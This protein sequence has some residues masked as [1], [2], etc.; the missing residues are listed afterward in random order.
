M[1]QYRRPSIASQN[2]NIKRRTGLG[3]LGLNINKCQTGLRTVPECATADNSHWTSCVQCRLV[4]KTICIVGINRY[5]DEFCRNAFSLAG[6]DFVFSDKVAF[7]IDKP[8]DI[9]LNRSDFCRQFASPSL[10]ALSSRMAFTA[11]DPN[12]PRPYSCPASSI[13]SASSDIV[14]I[15]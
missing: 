6:Y 7:I 4:S 2:R 11:Y 1:R 15:G 14:S 13:L 9:S 10:V 3:K 12:Q 8:F 5:Q